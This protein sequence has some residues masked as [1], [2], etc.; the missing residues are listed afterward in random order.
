[1]EWSDDEAEAEAKRRRKGKSHGRD[2]SN[3]VVS[4]ASTSA[5]RQ[6]HGLPS[7]PHFDYAP[8][9]G[10][11]AGSLYGEDT[12]EFEWEGSDAGSAISSRPAPAPYDIEVPNASGVLG[13][14]RSDR[15]LSR[16]RD[17]G[18]RGQGRDRGRGREGRG[19]GRTD[20]DRGSSGR[21]G[22]PPHREISNGS[23][24]QNHYRPPP[25]QSFRPEPQ[26]P[27]FPPPHYPPQYQAPVFP[28]RPQIGGY[29]PVSPGA[30]FAAPPPFPQQP[31]Y[32]P[33]PSFPPF[34]TPRFPAP[35]PPPSAP[36]VAPAI[37]PRFAAQYQM[38]VNGGNF[39][40]PSSDPNR[41][42]E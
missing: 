5:S 33:S 25:P 39:W 34:A 21:G 11:D 19:R 35:N 30:G 32:P 12:P 2:R 6:P 9:E 3:S 42:S 7:R 37:N 20:R 23:Y 38:M 1:M 13:T 28:P 27:Y 18:G 41:Y 22:P 26:Y 36:G 24:H 29:S 40:P 16:G 10:S 8:P 15:G 31:M 14:A 17:S 4:Q